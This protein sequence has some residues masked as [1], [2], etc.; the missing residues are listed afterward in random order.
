MDEDGWLYSQKYIYPF[1]SQQLPE[2][3]NVIL[4][5]YDAGTDNTHTFHLE[6]TLSAFL[7]KKGCAITL[8]AAPLVVFCQ[9]IREK[10]THIPCVSAGA[11]F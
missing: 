9:S 7:K 1:F 4:I 6:G 3:S 11:G 8:N 5:I 2:I 10:L